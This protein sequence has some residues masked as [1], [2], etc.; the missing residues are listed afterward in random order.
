VDLQI[1]SRDEWLVAREELLAL[2]KEAT[3]AGDR[4][5]ALRRAFMETKEVLGGYC[6]IEADTM[7]EA[8]EFARTWP[9][10]DRGYI[11]AELR[12]VVPH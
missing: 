3:R 9:R 6:V 1:V 2:E 4:L 7:D 8:V 11:T 12:L 10:I 5:A